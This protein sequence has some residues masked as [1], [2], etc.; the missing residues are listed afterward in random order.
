MRTEI[1]APAAPAR[2]KNAADTGRP[3]ATRLAARLRAL[4]R[5]QRC[6]PIG[7]E[8]AAQM[9]HMVQFEATAPLPSIRAAI[10]LP[11]EGGREALL[12]DHGRLKALVGRSLATR[13]FSGREVVSCL[14][15][16]DVSIMTITYQRA[17]GEDD[18]AAVVRELRERLKGELDKSV[19]DYV[20]IRGDNADAAERS[21]IVAAAPRE[22]VLAYLAALRAAGL[23]PVALDIGPAA[24]ARL[25]SALDTAGRYPNTLLVNFGQ[26]KSYMSVIWGRRLML[27]REFDFGEAQLAAR[28]GKTLDMP[29][30]VVLRLLYEHGFGGAAE[31]GSGDVAQ[32]ICEVLRPDF[33]ALAA[34][35]NKT[36]IYTAS[37]TRGQ[38]VERVYLLG[39]VARYPGVAGM[40]QRLV[41][42]PVEVVNAFSVF[43]SRADAA[44]TDELE[45][46]AGIGLATG[47]ALRGR[48]EHG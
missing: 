24:L 13:P 3:A 48:G 11:Y 44:A 29:D 34:E 6:E 5:P 8:I 26:K 47:L 15:G 21:A 39:S 25:V 16:A 35:V 28:L 30:D 27:D 19:I 12:A 32:T 36:L 10:S 40:V 33:A 43:A 46:I 20:A 22:R 37:K 4:V 7:L 14:P 2:A 9:L 45:P 18:A 1:P 41:S 42:M 31:A 23:E 17:A 38:S